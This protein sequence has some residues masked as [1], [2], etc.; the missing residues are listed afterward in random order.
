ML[1]SLSDVDGYIELNA[2]LETH[3][4]LRAKVDQC[5]ARRPIRYDPREKLPPEIFGMILDFIHPIEVYH[6]RRVSKVWNEDIKQKIEASRIS[7]PALGRGRSQI[8]DLPDAKSKATAYADGIL[9]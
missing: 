1:A 5:L 8:Y 6:L 4:E 9:A 3:C 2:L 7:K